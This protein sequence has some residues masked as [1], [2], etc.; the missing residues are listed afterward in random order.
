G[1][2]LDLL[3]PL[4]QAHDEPLFVTTHQTFELWF[5]LI[6]YE[7]ESVRTHMQEGNISEATRLLFRVVAIENLLTSQLDVLG[8]MT[9]QGFEEFRPQLGSA[10][11]AQ[12]VQFQ[13]IGLLSRQGND[14]WPGRD[15]LCPEDVLRLERRGHEPSIWGAFQDLVI[16]SGGTE[17]ADLFDQPPR[18][19]E[20]SELADA[21]IA[22]DQ[23]FMLWRL[24]H[25][26]LVAR[27]IGRK[28]GTGGTAGCG[29]LRTTLERRFF[30]E[31]L[32]AR[33]TTTPLD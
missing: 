10:S 15:H 25:L 33:P 5:R 30:P 26:R 12:S 20:L 3:K 7:L 32:A 6:L 24:R 14:D 4:S 31:L 17:L 21:M 1:E 23:A 28:K 16:R 13:E 11:G 27:M 18:H 8:T 22:Y 29:Y 19:P 9:A 2:L